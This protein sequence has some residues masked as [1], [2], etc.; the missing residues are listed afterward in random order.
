MG[1]KKRSL[2]TSVYAAIE[3]DTEKYFLQHL[4]NIYLP[5]VDG[6]NVRPEHMS[7]GSADKIIMSAIRYQDRDRAFAWLDEDFEINNPPSQDC[8]N[9]L[10][11]LWQVDSNLRVDFLN[12]KFKNLQKNYNLKNR[13]PILIV[14]QPISVESMVLAI[15]NEKKEFETLA[16]TKDEVKIQLKNLKSKL[17][18]LLNGDKIEVFFKNRIT[19]ELLESK[20]SEIYELDL[21]IK[22]ITK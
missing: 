11:E 17:S 21:L 13:K 4:I 1:S 18:Q 5:D 2:K 6:I 22:Q 14:S 3:G 20:R 9:K 16:N 15:A 10:A 12:S 8:K 19:K 7:G